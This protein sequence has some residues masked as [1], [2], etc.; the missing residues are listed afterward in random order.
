MDIKTMTIASPQ[1]FSYK[2]IND[3]NSFCYKLLADSA[4]FRKHHEAF[5]NLET[6]A[7]EREQ[8]GNIQ[9]ELIPNLNI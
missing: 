5:I 3:K 7:V 9:M 1:N 2:I 4:N 6:I 8:E